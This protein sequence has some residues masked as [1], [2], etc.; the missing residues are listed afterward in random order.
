MDKPA[1]SYRSLALPAV[2]IAGAIL[3]ACAGPKNAR[4]P[5]TYP[6]GLTPSFSSA[7]SLRSPYRDPLKSMRMVGPSGTFGA[8]RWKEPDWSAHTGADLNAP[9][10]REN[11]I[12]TPVFAIAKG[13]IV[14]VSVQPDYGLT[15]VLNSN[16]VE[17]LYAHLS[18]AL[19]RYGDNVNQGQQIALSGITGNASRS[20]EPP[21][22]H[23][24]LSNRM[25]LLYP[26]D[27]EGKVIH[28]NVINPCSGKDSTGSATISIVGNVKVTKVTLDDTSLPEIDDHDF[29][30]K[31]I[32]I[33]VPNSL[34]PNNLSHFLNVQNSAVCSG[35]YSVIIKPSKK[36]G[37]VYEFNSINDPLIAGGFKNGTAASG[38]LIIYE[39]QGIHESLQPPN[40]TPAPACPIT[41]SPT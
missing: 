36:G 20:N 12:G 14:T 25:P 37:A 39:N 15:I 33:G 31:D 24:E 13:T 5:V 30:A 38:A 1:R 32:P 26:N 8:L 23:F 17:S 2:T 40:P 19:V 9:Y 34:A 16:G 22:L 35:T 18:K 4:I 11:G 7:C 21:H 28:D 10:N 41:R 6:N 29:E 27:E 3:G